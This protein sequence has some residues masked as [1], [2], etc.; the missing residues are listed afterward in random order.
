MGS[1]WLAENFSS[2]FQG[3]LSAR[4]AMR[5]PTHSFPPLCLLQDP[6]PSLTVDELGMSAGERALG[7]CPSLVTTTR[8]TLTPLTGLRP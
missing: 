2:Y 1:T 3:K 7:H 5:T 4:D 8:C 6:L